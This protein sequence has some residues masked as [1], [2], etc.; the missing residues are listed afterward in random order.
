M[1]IPA[2]FHARNE[3]EHTLLLDPEKTISQVQERLSASLGIKVNALKYRRKILDHSLQV[4]SLNIDERS[5][6]LVTPQVGSPLANP[7]NAPR[8]SEQIIAQR[9]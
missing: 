2:R 9:R 4:K 5:V 3:N 8:W 6:I 7:G 1:M